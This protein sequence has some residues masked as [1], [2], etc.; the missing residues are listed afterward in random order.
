MFLKRIKMEFVMDKWYT[1]LL[2]S[3]F[4][5]FYYKN[6]YISTQNFISLKNRL[7]RYN[8]CNI[9]LVQFYFLNCS[10]H[11]YT[12]HSNYAPKN[13]IKKN[14]HIKNKIE[15]VNSFKTYQKL[16]P[17]LNFSNYSGKKL[18]FPFLYIIYLSMHE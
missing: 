11:A 10:L 1:R 12:M 7:Y 13:I 3:L 16:T 5:C 4:P 2:N 14:L 6:L 9:I 18:F 15:K 8:H 17:R